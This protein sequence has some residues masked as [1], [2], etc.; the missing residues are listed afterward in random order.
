M[1]KLIEDLNFPTIDD[2]EELIK[3]SLSPE[4][5]RLSLTQ[6]IDDV[7]SASENLNNNLGTKIAIY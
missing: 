3:I 4:H 1:E 7:Y 5:C 6:P 2:G